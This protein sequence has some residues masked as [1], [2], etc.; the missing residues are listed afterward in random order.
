MDIGDEKLMELFV[1]TLQ[2]CGL[3]ILKMSDDCI[4]Y[5]IFE[6]FDI[7]ATSFLHINTLSRLRASNLINEK[8]VRKSSDLRNKFF[9]LQHGDQ[10]NIESIKRTN[11]WMEVLT[12]SDE[13]KTLLREEMP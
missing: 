7:G 9:Q 11:E 3:N 10:W 8:I 5:N 2:K 12:L 1:D 6:E 4:A 13:I